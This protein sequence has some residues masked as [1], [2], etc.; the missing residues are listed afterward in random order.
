MRS[1]VGRWAGVLF[2]ALVSALC[3]LDLASSGPDRSPPSPRA[4]AAWGELT[5]ALPSTRTSVRL[6]N[7]ILGFAALTA[8]ARA[9]RVG[10][11]PNGPPPLLEPEVMDGGCIAVRGS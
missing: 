7:P 9:S 8:D 5:S 3:W 2:L 11:H 4:P 1:G 6:P 10:L